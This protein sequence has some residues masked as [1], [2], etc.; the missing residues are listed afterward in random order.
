M[1]HVAGFWNSNDVAVSKGPRQSNGGWRAAM[2]RANT[3]DCG[4]TQQRAA[5]STK[6]GVGHYWHCVLCTPRQQVMFNGTVA[7]TLGNLISCAA[8]AMGNI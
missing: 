7:K 6:W 5:R 1:R 2:C 3:R 4:I 8:I